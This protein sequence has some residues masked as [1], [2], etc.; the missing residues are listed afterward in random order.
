VVIE[1]L[2][3]NKPRRPAQSFVTDAQWAFIQLCWA[4]NPEERPD[5]AEVV[6]SMK[7]LHHASLEFRGS[8]K[9]DTATQLSKVRTSDTPQRT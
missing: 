4:V 7:A 1:I 2:K 5:C 8:A 9:P 6:R 3:G